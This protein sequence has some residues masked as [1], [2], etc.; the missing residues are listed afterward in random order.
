M[1]WDR[2]AR[3]PFPVHLTVTEAG[4]ATREVLVAHGYEIMRVERAGP[5][6]MIYYRR[7]GGLRVRGPG[8][9]RRLVI[10]LTGNKV[11]FESAPPRVLVD[12]HVQLGL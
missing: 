7:L 2:G 1:P 9:V 8:P 10:R 6:E 12:V 3:F 11:V 5:T 4:S